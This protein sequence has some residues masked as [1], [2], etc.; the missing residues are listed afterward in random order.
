MDYS[1]RVQGRNIYFG[2][3]ELLVS[4]ANGIFSQPRIAGTSTR[5]CFF[6]ALVGL[7]IIT[8][9]IKQKPIRSCARHE[10]VY[11]IMFEAIGG[12]I[13]VVIPAICIAVM[14]IKKINK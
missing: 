5:A 6:C 12:I 8:L 1:I 11:E 9:F 7:H 4:V 14:I 2:R 13:A 10:S 3:L